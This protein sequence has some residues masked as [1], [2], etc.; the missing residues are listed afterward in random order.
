MA[1]SCGPCEEVVMKWIW[2]KLVET[3]WMCYSVLEFVK[4][5][6][7][8]LDVFARMMVDVAGCREFFGLQVFSEHDVLG[9]ECAKP[10]CH[11]MPQNQEVNTYSISEILQSSRSTHLSTQPLQ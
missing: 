9:I 4:G 11:K 1:E 5:L 2:W 3:G 8:L 7:M 10:A 6:G